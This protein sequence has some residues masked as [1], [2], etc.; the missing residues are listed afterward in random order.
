MEDAA[1]AYGYNNLAL[2]VPRTPTVAKQQPLNKFTDL[3]RYEAA[4]AGYS[5]AFTFSLVRAPTNSS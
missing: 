4:F 3:L 5:E 1:I 2:T